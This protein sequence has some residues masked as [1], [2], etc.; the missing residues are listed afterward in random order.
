M[1]I[2]IVT[3]LSGSGKSEVMNILEDS[4]YYC[5]DNMPPELIPKFLSLSREMEHSPELIAFGVDIR[6]YLFFKELNDVIDTIENMHYNFDILFLE[7]SEETLV[8]R[9]KMSRRSHPLARFDNIVAGILEEKEKLS[10]L[11]KRAD[12]IIDTS[13]LTVKD[14]KAR[15]I[16]IY[17]PDKEENSLNII[18]TSFGFKYGI[19]IDAD[20]VMDVRFL[21]NPY[22]VENLKYK[23]GNDEEVFN[24]VMESEVSREFM[25]R[26]ESFMDFL[27]PNYRSEGKTQILIAVGCTG[28]QHRSVSV[29]NALYDYLKG[30]YGSVYKRHRDA[31]K[32]MNV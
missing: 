8:R 11:R 14:L 25:K 3:G 31:R 10:E 18:I 17:S 15:I 29:T 6:G 32:D 22:Y 13:K 12:R 2:T 20:I 1:H 27:I 24:Y 23:T 30:E 26:F 16:E 9:Y 28:G 7:A 5:V 19:P 4:G 21:P